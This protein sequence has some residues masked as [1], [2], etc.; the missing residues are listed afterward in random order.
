[1]RV[2]YGWVV[3]PNVITIKKWP[4]WIL[5]TYVLITGGDEIPLYSVK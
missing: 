3:K 5:I 4:V 1:M 2:A